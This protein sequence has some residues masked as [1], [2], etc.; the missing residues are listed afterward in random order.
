MTGN[1][2]SSE[3]LQKDTLSRYRE[4]C[5]AQAATRW[6]R[7]AVFEYG[8]PASAAHAL[9]GPRAVFGSEKH[10]T[11]IRQGLKL[12]HCILGHVV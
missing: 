4:W 12:L 7:N 10:M 9:E 5:F 11:L 2:F 8:F 6:E 1:L 3:L